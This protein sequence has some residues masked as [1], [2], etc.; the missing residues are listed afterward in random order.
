MF[1]GKRITDIECR[2]Q[3]LTKRVEELHALISDERIQTLIDNTF[4]YKIRDK[5]ASMIEDE[6]DHLEVETKAEI[7]RSSKYR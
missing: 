4:E 7:I 3:E 2:V 6:L 1:N 5:V